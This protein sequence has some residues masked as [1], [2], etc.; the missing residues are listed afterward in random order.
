MTDSDDA[1]DMDFVARFTHMIASSAEHLIRHE[2]INTEEAIRAI[3]AS[4]WATV[5]AYSAPEHFQDN[6]D[7]A[8]EAFES[9]RKAATEALKELEFDEKHQGHQWGNA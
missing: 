3:A 4:L 5:V 7:F 2:K 6:S 1:E 9:C 8:I